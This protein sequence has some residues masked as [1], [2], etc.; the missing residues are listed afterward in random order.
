[1]RNRAVLD[2]CGS[3]L[4]RSGAIFERRSSNELGLIRVSTRTF[5]FSDT[6]FWIGR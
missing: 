1:M 6:W 5:S 2:R 3:D 4:S